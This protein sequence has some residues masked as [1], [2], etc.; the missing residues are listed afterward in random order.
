VPL[1]PKFRVLIFENA[2]FIFENADF[3]FEN[4]DII[5]ENADFIFENAD[6]FMQRSGGELSRYPEPG[7]LKNKDGG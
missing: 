7:V 5:F 2:D 4:A 3:I 6:F 1:P